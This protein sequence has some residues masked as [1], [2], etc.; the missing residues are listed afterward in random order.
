MDVSSLVPITF[1]CWKWELFYLLYVYGNMYVESSVYRESLSKSQTVMINSNK[2][3]PRK[4]IEGSSFVIFIS[5]WLGSIFTHAKINFKMTVCSMMRPGLV[6]GLPLETIQ[7]FG[8]QFLQH[9]PYSAD[10][11]ANDINLFSPLKTILVTRWILKMMKRFSMK[12]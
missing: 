6:K 4:L 5:Y 8:W 11:E 10:F 7:M 3:F 2:Y 1:I 9:S 12:P